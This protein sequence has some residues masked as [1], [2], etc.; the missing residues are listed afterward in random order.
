MGRAT[1]RLCRLGMAAGNMINIPLVEDVLFDR[2][3]SHQPLIKKSF[4]GDPHRAAIHA[5]LV[6]IDE[7]VKCDSADLLRSACDW[8][9]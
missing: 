9:S 8:R 6:L 1:Y 3:A 5:A 7:Y 2:A 4:C